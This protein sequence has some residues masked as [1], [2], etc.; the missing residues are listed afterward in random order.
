MGVLDR[1][2][3]AFRVLTRRNL[4]N[5]RY[6]IDDPALWDIL[7]A[8]PSASGVR[9]NQTTA[10]KVHP[11]F[12][13]VALI[14][15]Y[16]AKLPLQV[17]DRETREVVEDH[18]AHLLM[19]HK[20]SPEMTAYHLKRAVQLQALLYG[21]G[22]AYVMRRGDG[23]PIEVIP[24][25][26]DRT[27]PVRENG[28]LLYVTIV[29]RPLEE[30]GEPRKLLPENVIHIRGPSLDGL[31]G[32]D[33]IRLA[34]DDIGLARANTV[35]AARF[36]R[37]AATPKVVILHPAKLTD[38]AFARLKKS[39]ESMHV[40]LEN[41]HKTAILE[42]GAQIQPLSLK[43]EETQLIENRKFDLVAVANWFGIPVHKVGGEGRTSYAS[44]E[45]E[46]QAFLDDCLDPWLV[47]WETEC[48]DKLLSEREKREQRL[49][50]EFKRQAMLRSDDSRRAAFYRSAL[51]GIPWM[52]PDE[53]RRLEN[54][55]PRDD[56]PMPLNVNAG[57]NDG[58][59]QASASLLLDAHRRIVEATMARM[60]KRLEVQWERLQKDG[61]TRE[62]V[63]RE[64]AAVIREALDPVSVLL[65]YDAAEYLRALFTEGILNSMTIGEQ[66]WKQR[67][68]SPES[69]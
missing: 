20:A 27:F 21:D 44:L 7:D 46:N 22:F 51:A 17:I 43:P 6:S 13:A 31:I 34:A 63:W 38:D 3:L 52:H 56:L 23:S 55:P 33:T 37:Q 47:C 66:A 57:G 54:L 19:R 50:F 15:G 42:E 9:V 60:A 29:G 4:E 8:E 10:L 41:A 24:L 25:S 69:E 53:V 26:S 48:W 28:R 67:R 62:S 2:R 14:S 40:G 5:P 1:V 65:G 30:G 12:R 16:V 35:Y 39:W 64:N 11:V 36:F 32:L 45:Q 59:D 61:V 68:C 58:Q 18:P 49:I